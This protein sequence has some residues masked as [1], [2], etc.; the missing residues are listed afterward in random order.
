MKK[1][2]LTILLAALILGSCK[3]DNSTNPDVQTYPKTYTED[4]RSIV[5]GNSKTTYDLIWDGSNRLVSMVSTPAPPA[6]QFIYQYSSGNSFTFDLYLNGSPNTHVT[7]WTNSMSYVDSTIQTDSSNVTTIEKYFYNAK[8]ELV[9]Q[10]SYDNSGG[11]MAP[12]STTNYTY[13]NSGNPL[14][15]YDDSGDS[16]TFTYY[17]NLYNTVNIGLPHMY[18]SKN[19]IKTQTALNSGQPVTATNFYF[20]DGSNRLIEDSAVVSGGL[21]TVIKSYTY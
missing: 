21:A 10:I 20:F 7:I 13:D 14:M 3:K 5:L 18:M 2:Q 19:L 15:Q 9:Q 8:N 16:V 17:P 4:I 11:T 1:I 6:T 12:F